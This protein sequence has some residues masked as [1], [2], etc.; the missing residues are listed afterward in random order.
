MKINGVRGSNILYIVLTNKPI[1][2]VDSKVL[3]MFTNSDHCQVNSFIAVEKSD[4]SVCDAPV[5]KTVCLWQD[6]DFV[7]IAQF[8]NH[9]D[10]YQ[11]LTCELLLLLFCNKQ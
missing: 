2:L 7:G 6:T 1:T 5:E 9:V 11:L 10:W 4:K 8:L 3:A